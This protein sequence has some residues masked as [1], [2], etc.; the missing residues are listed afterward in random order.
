MKRI[1]ALLLALVMVFSFAACGQEEKKD[2]DNSGNSAYAD[3]SIMPG[4]ELGVEEYAIAF[5][6]DSDM[7]SK[8]DEISKR[9]FENGTL[10]TIAEKYDLTEQLVPTF[11]AASG[12]AKDGDWAKIQSAGKMRIG[13]SHHLTQFL[14]DTIQ[15]TFH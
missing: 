10:G 13:A 8:V 15:L 2:G 14:L 12:N 7:V 9:L 3:L 1:F 5:R 4:V 6:K 11:E